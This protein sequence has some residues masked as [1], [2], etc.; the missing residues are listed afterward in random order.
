VAAFPDCALQRQ[1]PVDIPRR[2]P[3]N[4]DLV[5]DYQSS[6]L[7]VPN[8]GHTIQVPYQPGSTMTAGGKTY[9]LLQFH[10]HAPSEH[11]LHGRP[12][13]MEAHF[14]HQ[15]VTGELA[16]LGVLMTEGATNDVFQH[17]LDVLPDTEATVNASADF[18]AAAFLPHDLSYFSYEGSLTT[19]P[20]TED[21]KWLVLRQ[22][23]LVSREQVTRFRALEF[24]KDD[25]A[26]IG[27]ARPVQP[28]NGRLGTEVAS[29]SVSSVT[30]PSAGSAGLARR[31]QASRR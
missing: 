1:S 28:L 27:N 22:P 3:I 25:G 10:F 9:R 15:S 31:L 30:P 13:A 4:K 29:P 11:Y 23:I 19:P 14:V 24:L 12:A 21:V 8:N 26:F 17:I 16:V 5:L 2:A 7:T 20:C 6:K 18:D